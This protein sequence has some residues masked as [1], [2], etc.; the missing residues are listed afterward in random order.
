MRASCRLPGRLGNE[1]R[2]GVDGCGL[3]E[4]NS[5]TAHTRVTMYRYDTSV[6]AA[7]AAVLQMV[8]GPSVDGGYY[9]MGLR[10][11]EP[12]LFQVGT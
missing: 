5:A 8:I 9:L 4:P 1:R 3:Q 10:R 7:A 2:F 6:I 11:V 12:S